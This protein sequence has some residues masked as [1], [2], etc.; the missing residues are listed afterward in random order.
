[1]YIR[2]LLSFSTKPGG[3]C[4]PRDYLVLGIACQG[5]GLCDVT[6]RWL[7]VRHML[8]YLCVDML[9]YGPDFGAFFYE[10]Y[11]HTD[12]LVL[13]VYLWVFSPAHQSVFSL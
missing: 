3:E 11:L 8:D 1:M 2:S 9:G 13:R 5:Y 6:C 7:S 12:L 10:L 4:F